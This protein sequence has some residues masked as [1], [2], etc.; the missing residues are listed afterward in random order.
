MIEACLP[1]LATGLAVCVEHMRWLENYSEEW[2]VLMP[3]RGYRLFFRTHSNMIWINDE[4]RSA[5][6]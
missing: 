4:Y 6:L 3:T 2:R 5:L 1:T